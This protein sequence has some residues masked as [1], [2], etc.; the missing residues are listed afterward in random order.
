MTKRI[1]DKNPTEP[2]LD[3]AMVE[4]KGGQAVQAMNTEMLRQFEE[5]A[6]GRQRI[7]RALL[8]SPHP[9][10]KQLVTTLMRSQ[11][12]HRSL[13][14]LCT[15]LNLTASD[16]L[17]ICTEG[18]LVARAAAAIQEVGDRILEVVQASADVATTAG[19]DGFKDRQMLIQMA[20]LDKSAPQVQVN[21]QQNFRTGKTG[22]LEDVIDVLD[23]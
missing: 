10:A 23:E 7:I 16:L 19:V 3:E 1:P 8:T 4:A 2:T 11:N 13:Y 5:L 15:Q 20:G 9:K 6:G 14:S 21:L 18:H 17:N 22:D 12:G